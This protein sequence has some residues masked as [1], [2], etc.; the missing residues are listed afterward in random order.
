LSKTAIIFPG[1]GAQHVGMGKDIAEASSEARAI[2]EQADDILKTDLSRLCFDGPADRLN[3]TDMSQPAIF[4]T[5]V[6][7]WRALQANG[8]ADEF[9]PQAMAG[10]SLGEYTALHLAGWIGFEEG[11][12]LVARRGR[13]MQDAAEASKGGMVSVLGLDDA[14]T[15]ELCR[16]AAHGEVLAPANFNCPG[17]IVISGAVSAC[18]RAVGLAEKYGARMVPLVVAGA[19]HSPLMEPAA[20]GL[21][22]ALRAVTIVKGPLGVV[23]NVSADYHATPDTVR[24]LL[25]D[26]VAQ[27]IRWQA[28]MERL[29]ADGFERFVEVGPGRVLT[30]LMKKINRKATAV[31]ISTAASLVR[32]SESVRS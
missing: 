4:V 21:E 25:R 30:G 16:E 18:E 20:V 32:D 26:Q 31:N 10:L 13:L 24:T 28:S 5:S 22:P 2:F 14:K 9:A 27:P 7:V 15:S 3:A 6:A 1:Q 19:F 23:S 29:M 11:L 12:K 8:M 17:Q